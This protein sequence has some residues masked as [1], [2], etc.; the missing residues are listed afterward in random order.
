MRRLNRTSISAKE[1]TRKSQVKGL[2][3]DVV[4]RP[5]ADCQKLQ[6]VRTSHGTNKQS[7]E[8]QLLPQQEADSEE[9]KHVRSYASKVDIKFVTGQAG[10]CGSAST[11]IK[12]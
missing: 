6:R 7:F 2:R 3:R 1:L 12:T 5:S 8:K 9:A 10:G 4:I 11:A